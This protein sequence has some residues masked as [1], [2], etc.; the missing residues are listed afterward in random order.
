MDADYIGLRTRPER[1]RELGKIA[2]NIQKRPR[3]AC[4]SLRITGPSYR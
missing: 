3:R 4:G 2:G 1:D